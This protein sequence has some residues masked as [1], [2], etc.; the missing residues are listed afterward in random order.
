MSDGY[1][2]K[3]HEFQKCPPPP[4]SDV[5][6][7]NIDA[8][9]SGLPEI[10]TVQNIGPGPQDMTGW[11]IV[12]HAF[13]SPPPCPLPFPP[14]NYYFPDGLIL[15]PG[16]TIFIYSGSGS[17]PPYSPP[18]YFWNNANNWANTGDIGDL[19]DFNGNLVD[20]YSYGSC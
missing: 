5:R 9:F 19:I 4:P 20:S 6:I 17:T 15:N 12:S 2:F 11:Y 10:V 7:I 3:V 1:I 16:Q 14:D 18:N 8:G 13:A